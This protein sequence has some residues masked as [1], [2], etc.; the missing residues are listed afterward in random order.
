MATATENTPFQLE[1]TMSQSTDDMETL[2]PTY[3]PFVSLEVEDAQKKKSQFLAELESTRPWSEMPERVLD[4]IGGDLKLTIYKGVTSKGVVYGLMFVGHVDRILEQLGAQHGIPRGFPIIWKPGCWV[5]FFGFKIKFRNDDRNGETPI[6]ADG[7][8]WFLKFSGFLGHLLTWTDGDQYFWTGASKNSFDTSK[9]FA[10]DAKR[11]FEPYITRELLM[12]LEGRG[13]HLNAEMLSKNDQ[14]HGAKVLNE[15]P[16]FTSMARGV[17][18]NLVTQTEHNLPTRKG[19]VTYFG[20]ADTIALCKKHKLP[21]GSAVIATGV[22]AKDFLKVLQSVRDKMNYSSYMDV[23]RAILEKYPEQVHIIE[24]TMDHMNALGNRLEGI[25]AHAVL[26][27]P[28]SSHQEIV[29]MIEAGDT[30]IFKWKLPGYTVATMCCREAMKSGMSFAEFQHHVTDWAP[31]WCLTEDGINYWT[32]FAW[33]IMIRSAEPDPEPESLV[34][35]HIRLADQVEAEG[36]RPDIDEEIVKVCSKEPGIMIGPYTVVAPFANPKGDD[37]GP[38]E[39][40]LKQAGYPTTRKKKP[41]KSARGFIYLVNEPSEVTKKTG[42]MFQLPIPTNLLPWQKGKAEKFVKDGIEFV[43]SVPELLAKIQ[44]RIKVESEKALVAMN[45]ISPAEQQLRDSAERTK[46]LI[47]DR[48]QNL[49]A[50]NKKGVFMLVGP[51]CIGKSSLTKVLI[52]LGAKHCSADIHMG[53][54]FNFF[55][56]RDCHFRCKMD[57]V[58]SLKLG[59]HA[60][61]DNTNMKRIDCTQYQDICTVMDAELVPIVISPE[62]WLTCTPETREATIDALEIRSQIRQKL[63][64]KTISREVIEKTISNS[65]LDFKTHTGVDAGPDVD[66]DT[67]LST[68]PEPEYQ[69]GLFDDRNALVYRHSMVSELGNL[70]LQQASGRP[71][72]KEER[73]R[74]ELH[75][76]KN[77]YHVTLLSPNEMGKAKKQVNIPEIVVEEQPKALG[78]GKVCKDGED[79]LFVVIDWE[80]GQQF[81]AS[82]GLPKRDFHITVA[83][84]GMGDIHNVCKD[85]SVLI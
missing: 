31:R 81:R 59:H 17:F 8:A 28:D 33:D 24:G 36:V 43:E 6:N 72:I 53:P 76:G 77:E 29:A 34:A 42:P 75:R 27:H 71:N 49:D 64:G 57:V 79:V 26:D 82:L 58:D 51:Q 66:I 12:E 1:Q 83:W 4:A 80:W 16:V 9:T 48:I 39:K 73:L 10:S 70:G 19:P 32:R 18:L 84:T 23:L 69:N 22:A 11:L 35:R 56:L 5:K 60:I 15:M 21:V 65:L 85:S 62:L 67:W 30:E 41:L 2:H 54:E 47:I 14:T 40:S 78:L 55:K 7:V 3:I 37:F 25:V 38:L 50:R 61:V 52:E 44:S 68:Y 46:M 20:F 63:E 13:L 74:C 45:T